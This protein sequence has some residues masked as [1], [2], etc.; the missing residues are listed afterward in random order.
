MRN[1]QARF[2]EWKNQFCV[3]KFKT[4]QPGGEPLDLRSLLRSREPITR[5]KMTIRGKVPDEAHHCMHHCESHKEIKAP[6]ILVAAAHAEVIQMQP[7]ELIYQQEGKKCRYFTD[8]LLAWGNELWA[9][10]VKDDRKANDPRVIAR[11]EV[12]KNLLATHRIHFYF[13]KKSDICS[14]P[15][16]ST[17][18]S[19]LRYQKCPISP[20]EGIRTMFAAQPVVEIGGLDDD[21]IR[22][23]LR[24]VVEGMLHIDWTSRLSRTLWVNTNARPAGNKSPRCC[25]EC[26]KYSHQSAHH[27]LIGT[28]RAILRWSNNGLALSRTLRNSVA[29]E[30][31]QARWHKRQQQQLTS[32][33]LVRRREDNYAF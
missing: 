14:E 9:V 31:S 5:S 20:L 1:S 15:R 29:H 30:V 13:W 22:C 26:H 23:V 4:A 11:Y 24:L 32:P 25:R 18:R 17:A 12:I 10:E 8:A 6:V 28:D 2:V 21:D 16:L 33:T 19:I 27:D 7:F 3:I